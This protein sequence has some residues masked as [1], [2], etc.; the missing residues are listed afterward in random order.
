MSPAKAAGLPNP[1]IGTNVT[2]AMT[3][4]SATTG[5]AVNTKVVVS[6]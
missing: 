6:L 4:E 1:P 3:A 5:P 2:A